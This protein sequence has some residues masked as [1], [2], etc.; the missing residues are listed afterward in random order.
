MR[1]FVTQ[2]QRQIAEWNDRIIG[3]RKRL[4][5]TQGDMAKVIGKSR[6]AYTGKENDLGEI[7]LKDFLLGAHELGFDVQ[8]KDKEAVNG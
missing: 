1:A 4:K 2:E 8:L 5:I 3:R 6:T 7:R